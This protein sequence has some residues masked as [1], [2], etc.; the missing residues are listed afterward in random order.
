MRGMLTQLAAAT[1]ARGTNRPTI[2]AARAGLEAI[3]RLNPKAV[4]TDAVVAATYAPPSCSFVTPVIG[5]GGL[6]WRRRG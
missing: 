5:S 3:R 1:A 2:P 4:N 6:M